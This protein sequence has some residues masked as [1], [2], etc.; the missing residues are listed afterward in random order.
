MGKVKGKL[1]L[2]CIS[3]D[4]R[5]A[6]H[7]QLKMCPISEAFLLSREKKTASERLHASELAR[8]HAKPSAIERS[9]D[10]LRNIKP[11][12]SHNNLMHIRTEA[13]LCA[14]ARC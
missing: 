10:Y 12:P 7:S 4:Q 9:L 11:L 14:I 1:S 3:R 8:S 5:Q 2:L 13:L 6:E